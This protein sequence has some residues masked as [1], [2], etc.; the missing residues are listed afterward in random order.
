M[1]KSYGY[2]VVVENWRHT[3]NNPFV[4]RQPTIIICIHA[5]P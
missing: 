5:V 2:L 1:T 3:Q 4:G